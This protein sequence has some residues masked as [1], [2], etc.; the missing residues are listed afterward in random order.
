MHVD[1]DIDNDSEDSDVEHGNVHHTKP[2]QV[3]YGNV[4]PDKA[5]DDVQRIIPDDHSSP[6][7][8]LPTSSS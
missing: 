1:T 7:P 8:I 6:S 5:K 3:M 2:T 4:Q